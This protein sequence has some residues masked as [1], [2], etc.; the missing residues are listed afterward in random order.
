MKVKDYFKS[1]YNLK[2]INSEPKSF[3]LVV[4][5]KM[6]EKK[7]NVHEWYDNLKVDDSEDGGIDFIVIELDGKIIPLLQENDV[8]E[9]LEE[10]I[11]SNENEKQLE[12]I[13]TNISDIDK[14]ST[15]LLN[16]ISRKNKKLKIDFIQSKSGNSIQESV[17]IKMK[18]TIE[19]LILNENFSSIRYSKKLK[20]NIKFIKKLIEAISINDGA[21]EFNLFYI[22]SSETTP[23][24]MPKYNELAE[25]IKKNVIDG[26]KHNNVNFT[27]LIGSRLIE[28]LEKNNSNRLQLKINQKNMLYK[29]NLYCI[30]L[31][32]LSELKKFVSLNDNLDI[33]L[34]D[35][36]VR[37]S[38]KNSSAINREIVS[39]LSSK[40]LTNDFWWLNNGITIIC[41]KLNF[42][43]NI[44]YVDS[45]QIVNGLQSV[46][47]IYDTL[48]AGQCI[49]QNKNIM[50]RFLV[51]KDDT[52]VNL[53][54]KTTNNQNPVD[55]Y[56]LSSTQSIHKDIES[57]FL[58]FGDGYFYDR[59]KNYYK[60]ISKDKN[61]IFDIKYTFK[62]Y[63]AVF[64]KIPSQVRTATKSNFN[65]KHDDV[66]NS[67]INKNAYLYSD[68]LDRN[69][70]KILRNSNI[71]QE[72][73]EKNGV[74]IITY[75]L[76][77]SFIYTTLLKDNFNYTDKFI[78]TEDINNVQS[79]EI[80]NALIKRSIDILNE[81]IAMYPSENKV[82]L[83]R[84]TKLENDIY[85]I[86][87]Q[88]CNK[89]V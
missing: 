38:Y 78:T 36:N 85:T 25:C 24:S 68:L 73:K 53:I 5:E 59:R 67:T 13:L 84:K 17:L 23:K 27:F 16:T 26:I 43:K 74:S 44:L 76:H 55:D 57:F 8:S 71:D 89:D 2:G 69:I 41:E 72:F 29:K 39:T 14:L 28:F 77:L 6:Y 54:I 37:D 83:A 70:Q 66:F 48:E 21:I 32:K 88:I 10:I 34:F 42:T 86:L 1:Q 7:I 46:V 75:S 52:N 51:E 65:L 82:Y 35:G 40:L 4:L 31:V 62:T 12:K 60:N 18:T 3:E 81:I 22:A 9:Q 33:S 19:D 50:V 87:K 64:L 11:F 30:G 47:A 63:A 15:F 61:K 58:S 49:N 79:L 45:P 20:Y 80:N 56:L